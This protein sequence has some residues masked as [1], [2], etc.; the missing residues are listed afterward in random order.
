MVCINLRWWQVTDCSDQLGDYLWLATMAASS[1][2]L[3]CCRSNLLRGAYNQVIWAVFV[4]CWLWFITSWCN[5][6]V[7][8]PPRLLSSTAVLSRRRSTPPNLVL[9]IYRVDALESF[10]GM[11]YPLSQVLNFVPQQQAWIV[12]R[13]GRY[14]KTLNPVS[15]AC[16]SSKKSE[17]ISRAMCFTGAEHP[18]TD[19]GPD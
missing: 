10:W 18:D 17:L 6:F 8:V 4:S 7:Q 16:L 15:V 12:E 14:L 2:L 5:T 9:F 13:F 11:I 1:M 3:H 19:C